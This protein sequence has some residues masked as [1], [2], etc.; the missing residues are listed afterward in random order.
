MNRQQIPRLLLQMLSVEALE[1]AVWSLK[2]LGFDR[3]AVIEM[4]DETWGRIHA[5]SVVV[6]YAIMVS[7]EAVA[8][9]TVAESLGEHFDLKTAAAMLADIRSKRGWPQ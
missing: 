1:L 4:L 3:A 9:C 6:S 7:S 2:S 5:S 8:R